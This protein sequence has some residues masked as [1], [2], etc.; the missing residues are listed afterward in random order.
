MT[1]S[2]SF[3]K[4]PSR[5]SSLRVTAFGGVVLLGVTLPAC[6]SSTN[7]ATTTTTTTAAPGGSPSATTSASGSA[8]SSLTG[9]IGALSS[10]VKAAERKTFKAVYTTT[11][12]GADQTVTIEQSPPK[13]VFSTGS[14][15]V[16]NTGTASYYCSNSGGQATCYNAGTSNPLAS[17]VAL[18]S[19]AAALTEL[20]AAQAEAAIHA[21]GY[22][23]SFSTQSFAG[24][25]ATCA[26][27]STAGKNAKYCVTKQGILAYAGSDASSFTLTSYSS[28]PPA[29][30]FAL[31]SG[32]TVVT[33][34]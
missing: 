1:K 13:S 27:I 28:S 12:S 8:D 24:E 9:K 34:P 21:A 26:N 30:D 11:G 33:I 4:V 7:S 22:S 19:P 25:S 16:I 18:Y 29:G 17:L 15:S 20:K 14:G 2:T 10:Q 5:A 23:V 31:P 32:A 3:S 6:S